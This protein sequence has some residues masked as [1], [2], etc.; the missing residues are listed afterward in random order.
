MITVRKSAERGETTLDWLDSKHTFSF[1]DYR[2]EKY[3]NFGPLRVINEDIVAP[4]QGFGSHP[5]RD[6]EII[7][8]IIEGELEHRDNLGTGAVIRKGEIQRMSAGT[9]VVHSEFN[10]SQTDPVH[11]LQIWILPEKRGIPAAYEQKKFD[12]P[13]NEWRLLADAKGEGEAVTVH[14]DIRLFAAHITKN[15]KL[16]FASNAAAAWVQVVSGDITV[17]EV[18]A[19]AGDG[20][21]IE[22]ESEFEVA[23]QSEAE[24]LLFEIPKT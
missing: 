22:N 10:H 5:H 13:P 17:G 8:Y 23:A 14:Q 18:K 15:S 2:D 3:M 11:L 19:S 16:K 4:G 7:T 9:G 12:L 1:G 20:L 24:I 6:M 21:G